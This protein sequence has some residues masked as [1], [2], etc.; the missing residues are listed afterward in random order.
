MTVDLFSDEDG[1]TPLSHEEKTGLIPSW[2]ALRHELN[3]VEQA[4]IL[5]GERWAFSRGRD[6]LD[7]SV[8]RAL[9]KRMFGRVWSWA[10]EYSREKNRRIGSDS[11]MIPLDLRQLLGDTHYWVEKGTYSPDEIAVRFHHRLVLIHPFPNGNGR[12]GRLAADLLIT[13]LGAPRFTWSASPIDPG[14]ARNRYI[15]AQRAADAHDIE[16]LL[17]FARS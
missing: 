5:E 16:P 7:E 12:H 11:V 6:V 17:V 9:H 8:L 3:E 2:I 15:A 13:R 10:G 14:E 4:N 1:N